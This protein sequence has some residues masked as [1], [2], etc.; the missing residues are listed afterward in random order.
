MR[1]KRTKGLE[2]YLS[3]ESPVPCPS[4]GI[5]SLPPPSALVVVTCQLVRRRGSSWVS[6]SSIM[7]VLVVVAIRRCSLH[8]FAVA[9]YS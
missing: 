1:K 2:T 3:L 5:C 4:P 9:P 8:P 7:V 6:L